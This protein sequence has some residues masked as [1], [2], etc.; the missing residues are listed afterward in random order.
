MASSSRERKLLFSALVIMWAVTV[1]G[2]IGRWRGGD[3]PVDLEEGRRRLLEQLDQERT[4]ER[5]ALVAAN[6]TATAASAGF[7]F[8]DGGNALD[9]SWST[10][11][12]AFA[13]QDSESDEMWTIT[14]RIDVGHLWSWRIELTDPACRFAP[15]PG[16]SAVTDKTRRITVLCQAE[17]PAVRP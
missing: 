11:T 1:A 8:V 13:F 3:A 5:A 6:A 16:S 10:S 14:D 4:P 17:P 15:V 7:V 2:I 9:L 12:A